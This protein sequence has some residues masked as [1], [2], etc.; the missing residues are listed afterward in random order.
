M[1]SRGGHHDAQ[2][3]RV[4]ERHTQGF[5]FWDDGVYGYQYIS[6]WVYWGYYFLY[7]LQR[8]HWRQCGISWRSILFAF[9]FERTCSY[10]P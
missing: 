8:Q 2:L 4:V 6:Y 10:Q 1:T 3:V 5:G 9:D 7:G